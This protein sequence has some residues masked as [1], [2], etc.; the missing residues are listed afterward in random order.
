MA[1]N[2]PTWSGVSMVN[3]HY[4]GGWRW[5]AALGRR[6]S[7]VRGRSDS[8]SSTISVEKA[9][10]ALLGYASDVRGDEDVFE[11]ENLLVA[12]GVVLA[13]IWVEHV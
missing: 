7:R 4:P 10:I 2:W 13:H 5:S 8:S 1:R 6:G 12:I 3:S 9:R 11:V